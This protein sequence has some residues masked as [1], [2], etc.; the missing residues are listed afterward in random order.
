MDPGVTDGSATDATNARI[1]FQL[2]PQPPRKFLRMET[3]A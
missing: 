3:M 1:F 2:Q